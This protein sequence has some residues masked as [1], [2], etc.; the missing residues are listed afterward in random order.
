[1]KISA[2]PSVQNSTSLMPTHPGFEAPKESA[3]AQILPISASNETEAPEASQPL[4]PQFAELAKRRRALQLQE[5]A[6]KEREKALSSQPERSGIDISRLKS[7]PLRV[8]QEAGVTYDQLTEHLLAT[9]EDA[10]VR[11]LEAKLEALEQG[12][13]KKFVDRDTQAERQV[14]N[15]MRGEAER[16]ASQGDSFELVRETR[17]IPD[18]MT[19]IERTYRETGEVL[20]VSEA[21]GLVEEEL[22]KDLNKLANVNKIRSQFVSQSQ[23]APQQ[24]QGA[25]PTLRNRDTAPIAM[26]RRARALAAWNN[27][28]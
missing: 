3:P 10:K 14:L 9:Q 2:V 15:E 8:L 11:A 5:R 25:R 21:L 18:V 27:N 20:D 23:T 12:V 26:S 6:L 22:F 13:E 17:S 7:E 24:Q 28:K 4:S 1:M 19:L 16:L